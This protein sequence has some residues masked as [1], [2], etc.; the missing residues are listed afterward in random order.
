MAATIYTQLGVHT[1][2]H[3]TLFL[4][5]HAIILQLQSYR[6]KVLEILF[7]GPTVIEKDECTLPKDAKRYEI[8][9]I[10]GIV[11]L[12]KNSYLLVITSRKSCGKIG[13]K[14]IFSLA[15]VV[16]IPLDYNRCLT[17]LGRKLTEV[18]VY[19]FFDDA[20]ASDVSDPISDASI[21][22]VRK[23]SSETS[24]ESF[25][26][27]N[28]QSGISTSTSET[29]L[30]SPLPK[31]SKRPATKPLKLLNRIIRKTFKGQ[32][33]STISP[34]QPE[35]EIDTENEETDLSD[36]EMEITLEHEEK[37]PIL[38]ERVEDENQENRV[39]STE[40]KPYYYYDGSDDLGVLDRKI[41]KNIESFFSHGVFYFS[42]ELDITHSLQVSHNNASQTSQLF[43]WQMADKR[44]WWNE[45]LMDTFIQA[46]LHEWIT[47]IMQGYI[48]IRE[49]KLEDQSLNLILISRRSR[50]RAGLR[51]QRRGVNAKGEVANFVETEQIV[52]FE[53][54]DAVHWTSFVQIRGSIPLFFSQSPFSL[55]P[56]P[57]LERT[58]DENYAAI[59]KHFDSINERYGRITVLNLVEQS[60][61]EEIIG[62]EYRRYM[63]RLSDSQNHYVEFDFHAECKG[64]KYENVQKL[65]SLLESSFSRS[66]YFWIGPSDMIF[67]E[68]TGVFRTNCMD[69]LDRT[70]VVQSALARTVLNIQLMRL[71][72]AIYPEKGLSYF[73]DF[74]ITF[75]H[76]WAN[77]GDAISLE[78]ASSSA[79]KG[80]FTRYSS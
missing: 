17:L 78:Y 42:N 53:L 48:E 27:T 6:R 7:D 26:A 24:T 36:M 35:F 20:E 38:E 68:Q 4:E 43:L 60:G 14:E 79:L 64:M 37:P 28:E 80:D 30:P 39:S 9:G 71:G 44:F 3:Y 66:G 61:K 62:G 22:S 47:V 57:I 15:K 25:A 58:E 67:A 21:V 33:P 75:N 32:T 76:M 73:N 29:D 65:I 63:K 12:F 34:I 50:E 51:F 72:I 19:D 40:K 2:R 1:E 41:V 13:G 77:N 74:E 54:E 49:C 8:F 31:H 18:A 46:G 23:I 56:T 69:C 11:K 59:R 55:K 5:R 45:H 52:C 70:N 10:V 16:A